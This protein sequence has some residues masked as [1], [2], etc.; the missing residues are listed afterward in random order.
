MIELMS[1][2]C[3]TVVTIF[4]MIGVQKNKRIEWANDPLTGLSCCALI[5]GD[6]SLVILMVLR[7]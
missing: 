2:I 5:I 4:V 7:R 3:L 6:I 1:V